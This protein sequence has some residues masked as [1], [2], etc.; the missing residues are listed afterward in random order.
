MSGNSF[1]LI[2]VGGGPA[3]YVGAIRAAQLGLNTACVESRG[4]L[5]GTCLNVGCIPSKALLETSH[6]Y[7]QTREELD[8]HG[9][10]TGKVDINLE[11]MHTR[12]KDVVG[13]LTKGI[14]GL[15]KKNKVTYIKGFGSFVD[16]NT[17]E[18]KDE[19]GI[20]TSLTSNNFMIAT[21]SEPVEL[22]F[23]PFDGKVVISST[24]A[25]ELDPVPKHLVIIG[26]GV[27][28]LEMGSV[29]ARLGAKVSIIEAQKT[30]L[31]GMDKAI[32]TQATR[33]FAKQGMEIHTETFLEKVNVKGKKATVICKQKDKPLELSADKV[34]VAVGRKPYT[35][36]LGLEKIGIETEQRGQI[37]VDQNYRTTLPHIYAVGDVIKGPMLAHKAE[38]EGVAVAEIIAGHHGHVNYRAIPG[39][40][41]TFPE[42]ASVGLTEEQCKE[43][44]LNIKTGKFPFMANGRAKTAG[45]TDGFVKI[46]ADAKT[47]KMVGFHIIGAGASELI[48][49]AAIAFEYEASAEDIGRSVHAHPTLAEAMK[50]A[51]LD[52]NKSATQF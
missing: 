44:G 25:L 50:Q 30:I 8:V 32:C 40:V 19:T 2:V 10:S 20:T 5:G 29:W 4:T 6:L 7:L 35:K 43:Q 38:E 24:E 28:G 37:P 52:V 34:L 45:H 1:D 15:F 36:N 48:A 47:D 51:A 13:G 33:I 26:G 12:R 22:P 31:P 42:I 41:Y 17:L 23:A 21:G 39:V 46:I 14:E 9:I 11:K 3:G 27:I 18:V 16:P 49:E